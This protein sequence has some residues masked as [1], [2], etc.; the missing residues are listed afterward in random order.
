MRCPHC[1]K[2]AGYAT[3]C[4]FCGA[5]LQPLP[6]QTANTGALLGTGMLVS[7]IILLVYG[8]IQAILSPL[9][10]L[11]V[12]SMSQDNIMNYYMAV[13]ILAAVRGLIIGVIGLMVLLGGA[14]VR[15]GRSPGTL[16][17][18]FVLGIVQAVMALITPFLQMIIGA[19][20]LVGIMSGIPAFLLAA[21]PVAFLGFL[22]AYFS[23]LSWNRPV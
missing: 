13:Y 3:L 16:T 18:A 1:G 23:R 14:A 22:H 19:S 8:V 21:A 20:P 17:V 5:A 11:S 12:S 15:R 2:D 4:P 7:G 6:V 10:L 9:T